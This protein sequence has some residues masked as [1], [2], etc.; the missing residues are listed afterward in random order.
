MFVSTS[1]MSLDSPSLSPFSFCQI[2]PLW[3][4]WKTPSPFFFPRQTFFL[5]FSLL[6]LIKLTKKKACL[7][8]AQGPPRLS[9]GKGTVMVNGGRSHPGREDT[10]IQH[11]RRSEGGRVFRLP[12]RAADE[13]SM[14]GWAAGL[15]MGLRWWRGEGE[16]NSPRRHGACLACFPAS[17][18]GAWKGAGRLHPSEKSHHSH[19]S[20]W[21][22]FG[23]M[24][25]GLTQ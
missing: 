24:D 25:L 19:S 21:M 8:R 14:S 10:H 6:F 17:R 20:T 5:P 7:V 16:R 2:N 1:R 13:Q 23:L 18:V 9:C 12:S 3:L 15:L 22:L 4:F 11:T